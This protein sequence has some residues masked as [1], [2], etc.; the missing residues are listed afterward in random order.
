[1]KKILLPAAILI[2]I[3]ITSCIKDVLCINGN[4]VSETQS[5]TADSFSHAVNTTSVDV[6]Y[7]KAD[8]VSISITA[9]SNIINHIVANTGNGRLEIRTDPRNACFDYTQKPVVTITSPELNSMDLTGS[10]DFSADSLSGNSVTV[11][12][13]G[14]GNLHAKYIT[15][16]ELAVTN[17]GSGNI[18]ISNALSENSDFTV[19]GSGDMEIKGRSNIGVMRVTGSGDIKSDSFTLQSA[20]ETIT[21]SGNIYTLVQNSLKAVISGSGNIYLSGNPVL[22]QTTTGSG[23]VI[24]R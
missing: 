18:E 23:R 13:T 24:N 19:T 20:T 16:T 3:V 1:M 21:G 6:I 4:G 9:E 22:D 5:R 10:G 7:K 11:R 8:S 12:I 14:S 17:T 2:L 15:C